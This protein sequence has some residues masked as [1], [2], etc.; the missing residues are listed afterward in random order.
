MFKIA[1]STHKG[2][3]GKTVTAINLSAGLSRT[4]KT[5]LVDLDPQAHATL[6]L[7]INV[8]LNDPTVADLLQD[9]RTSWEKV[10]RS[11]ADNLSVIPSNIRLARVAEV[12]Y[13]GV[14]REERL[15]LALSKVS[16]YE[17]AV[18]DCPPSLSTLTI[19]AL[20]CADWILIPCEMG[21]RSADGLVD[22]LE[23]ISMLK[24]A[25][26]DHWRILLT[27]FDVRK[28]VTNEAVLK[29]L[30]PYKERILRTRVGVCEA[31]NQSQIAGK[32]VFRYE[33]SG[34]GAE[35][36]QDLAR[37]IAP[38]VCGRKTQTEAISTI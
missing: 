19:T 21:A 25:E 37:E 6:G 29:A 1:I 38:L 4:K 14:R 11:T 15:G 26:F 5:L 36:Y 34:R 10:V 23:L 13:A 18:I 20:A 9:S 22:L 8:G 33:P 27:K 24:G 3:T 35:Y 31:L 32:D 7:G 2:G 30:A 28:S 17:V 12:L 16:G